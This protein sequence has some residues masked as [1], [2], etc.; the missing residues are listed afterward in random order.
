MIN[1][2]NEL[3]KYDK[4]TYEHCLNVGELGK[5][6]ALYLNDRFSY[7]IDIFLINMCG[8]LHDIGKT[9][10]DIEILNKKDKLTDKEYSH[11]QTHPQLGLE[12]VEGLR[13]EIPD[14]IKY[15]ILYHHKGY[16]KSGY[17]S[18]DI[19]IPN[20]AYIYINIITICDVYEALHSKRPYKESMTKDEVLN[21]MDQMTIFN[22]ELYLKFKEF[23]NQTRTNKF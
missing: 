21:I 12:Y 11:I 23:L 14:E 19:D 20:N 2:I 7:N 13:C 18:S 15:C 6:F 10:L 8:L 3:K 9:Q 5:K 22:P 16:D 4:T 17:P 1:I